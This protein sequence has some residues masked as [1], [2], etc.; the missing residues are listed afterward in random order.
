[1]MAWEY[2]E[3]H[4]ARQMRGH[5]DNFTCLYKCNHCEFTIEIPYGPFGNVAALGAQAKAHVVENHEG[6]TT[7]GGPS[8]C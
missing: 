7:K 1:M 3:K 2:Q 6:T 8:R 5:Q 4:Y